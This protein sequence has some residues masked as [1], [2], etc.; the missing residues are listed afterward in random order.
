MNT[1]ITLDRLLVG[2]AF[3]AAFSSA[4]HA[5]ADGRQRAMS[6]DVQA[7]ARAATAAGR[8]PTGEESEPQKPMQSTKTRA[9]RKAETLEAAKQHKLLPAGETAYPRS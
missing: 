1:V 4:A 7:E 3:A 5:Q 6:A 2:V 8:I 9:E